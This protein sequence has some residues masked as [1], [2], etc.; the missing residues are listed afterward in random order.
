MTD[1]PPIVD[2][3]IYLAKSDA[4]DGLD[5]L[6]DPKS[7]NRISLDIKGIRECVLYV[8]P[9]RVKQ[10]A[11]VKFFTPF[12]PEE[13]F[14]EN[15]STGAVL[16][17]KVAERI[18]ILTF[19]QGRHLVDFARVE[20]NFGLRTALNLIDPASLR[21][22]DTSSLE[23]P[24]T[25]TRQQTAVDLEL[26]NFGL[27][28]ERD[29]LRAVTGSPIDDRYGKRISGKD[30]L[31]LHIKHDLD[32]L[33]DLLESVLAD[34][35]RES[36]KRKG[37]DWIDRMGEVKDESTR[38]DLNRELLERIPREGPK[39]WLAIPDI[40][41]SEDVVG[42][43]Y[44]ESEKAR[45]YDDLRISDLP[46]TVK[47][48]L[49]IPRLQRRKIA[50]MNADGSVVSEWPIYRCICAEIDYRDNIYI[51][52]NGTWY[53]V[54]RNFAGRINESF[55]K[56]PRYGKPLP[57]FEDK[58][59]TDYNL[60]VAESNPDSFVLLDRKNIKVGSAP[61]PV[62]PCDLF[63]DGNEF[64]HVKRYGGSSILSHLFNQGFVSGRLFR[65]DS[66]FRK[67][68]NGKLPERFRMDNPSRTP[69]GGKYHVIFAIIK[70]TDEADLS[71]PFFSRI[72]L[73]HVIGELESM[74]FKAFLARVPSR[75]RERQT[76]TFPKKSVRIP[77][78]SRL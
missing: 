12:V 9:I 59:E 65:R 40:I 66:D 28:I 50:C 26:G 29:L 73:G 10:P 2:L 7:P 21:G 64:I 78:G 36:Y 60:R 39:I 46:E 17:G 38:H 43:K 13:E 61:S 34:Y 74:G 41:D 30:A 76:D 57:D 51:L 67:Q 49:D 16:I 48:P 63:R 8:K 25:N 14:G 24:S 23:R 22:M 11:W 54:D 45:R 70:E 56:I 75:K 27:D 42:F 1:T 6:K 47:P 20:V 33:G 31:K 15:V 77:P 72:S 18:L 58:T 53:K 62:E 37:F 4:C 69:A 19:G 32:G 44:S 55:A 52:N 71:I 3:T 68:L 5:I 35:E